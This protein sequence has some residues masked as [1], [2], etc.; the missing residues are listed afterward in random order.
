MTDRFDALY[1]AYLDAFFGILGGTDLSVAADLE[2]GVALA[3]AAY[4]AKA[5]HEPRGRAEV[6]EMV[7]RKLAGG[8]TV[9]ADD[10]EKALERVARWNKE[11]PGWESD[12]D[13]ADLDG[14][15][16]KIRREQ[17]AAS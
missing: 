13:C 3:L 4:D 11:A 8:A 12:E 6:A 9:I 1:Q 7:E 10:V 17:G 5:G 16:A 2:A 15:L 14:L